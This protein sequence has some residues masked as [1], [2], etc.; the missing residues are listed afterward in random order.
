MI[1]MPDVYICIMQEIWKKEIR[2]GKNSHLHL[3]PLIRESN[4]LFCV[5]CWILPSSG[6]SDV[7]NFRIYYFGMIF[8]CCFSFFLYFYCDFD[9]R[10]GSQ[11]RVYTL[12]LHTHIHTKNWF[13]R[14]CIRD[15]CGSSYYFLFVNFYVCWRNISTLCV[16]ISFMFLNF[17]TE[18]HGRLVD[19]YSKPFKQL[20]IK[21]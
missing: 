16:N 10:N 14:W 15:G 2:N 12:S 3:R 5:L 17:I 7:F 19:C 1:F 4:I 18:V 6:L 21:M 8:C 11:F 20:D 9:H 13:S